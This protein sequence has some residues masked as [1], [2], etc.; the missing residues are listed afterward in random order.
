MNFC[1]LKNNWRFLVFH[2]A[3]MIL[4]LLIATTS[5]FDNDYTLQLPPNNI[6]ANITYIITIIFTILFYFV[7][8]LFETKNIKLQNLYLIL[9]IPLSIM[10]CIANPLGKIPDEEQHVRKAMAISKGVFLSHTD[11]NG[12]PVDMFNS[13]VNE[14]VTRS[15]TNYE[16]A[17][18]RITAP[19]TDVEIPLKYTMANYAPICHLPQAFGIFITRLFGAGISVQCYAARVTNMALAIYLMYLA[20]KYVPLKKSVVFFLGLLP[21]TIQEFASM[22]SDAL[23]ISS[24]IFYIS[25]IF[26]LKYDDNKKEINK[27]DIIILAITSVVVSLCKIVYVPLCLLLFI[28][29]K[30]KF[31]SKKV[32][33]IITSSI[34]I[35]AILLNIIWLVY[36]S[37]LLGETNPGVNSSK[38]VK[39][40]LTHPLSYCLI[41]FRTIHIFFQTFVISLCG[42]G[43]GNYNVQASVLFVLPCFVIFAFLFFINDDTDKKKIDVKSKLIYLF[44]FVSIVVLIYTSLYVAWTSYKRPIILGVQSRYFL[45]IIILM[46][47]IL[48]NKKIILTS[49][50]ENKYLAS[51]MLFFNL[52]A[53]SCLT[54]TYI[55][56]YII[57]Y[58]IK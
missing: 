2:F 1:F 34:F 32:K 53:L 44:V 37:G 35:F 16:Q 6:F 41:L 30:E 29:P 36:S 56:D 11:E 40:I 54:Y 14:L 58:Y 51:F 7:F 49:K 45:P 25:Y 39:Y 33:H 20:I 8:Q 47:F 23:A 12:I 46:A 9:V 50:M 28:L 17:W 43:L 31:T 13:K 26:Y 52:N 19:E 55:F 21:L 57:E 4:I 5:F 27:K 22:S 15:V 48:D 24:C 42:E 10:Y 3:L 18:S 38:Q